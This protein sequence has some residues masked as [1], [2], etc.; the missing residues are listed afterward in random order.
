MEITSDDKEM[1]PYKRKPKNM[2]QPGNKVAK[3][4]EPL[5]ADYIARLHHWIKIHSMDDIEKI[6][7]NKRKLRSLPA[8]DALCCIRLHEAFQAGGGGT[9]EALF[10]R[11]I[12]KPS[13]HTTI[14][15]RIKAEVQVTHADR[16]KEAD[17]EA[18]K[19]IEAMAK[20]IDV[21]PTTKSET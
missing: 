19:L 11:L 18:A 4:R 8:T 20:M 21:T 15:A 13:Q 1:V 14:D 7:T 5:S 17:E 10:D 6:Y 2:F 16:V 3:G 12:G 9:M